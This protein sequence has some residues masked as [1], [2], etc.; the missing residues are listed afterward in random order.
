[1]YKGEKKML[2]ILLVVSQGE[3]KMM[4]NPEAAQEGEVHSK[5]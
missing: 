1:M 2:E 5:S 3:M 4:L